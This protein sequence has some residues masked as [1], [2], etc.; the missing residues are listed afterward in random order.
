MIY[1]LALFL[2]VVFSLAEFCG[3]QKIFAVK[4]HSLDKI[5]FIYI[6]FFLFCIAAFRYKTGKRLDGVYFF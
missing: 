3:I 2:L 6:A 1:Y 5:I 4:K